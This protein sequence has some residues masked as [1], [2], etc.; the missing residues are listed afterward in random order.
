MTTNKRLK[1]YVGQLGD[2]ELGLQGLLA[3]GYS[4]K[5]AQEIIVENGRKQGTAEIFVGIRNSSD[6]QKLIEQTR[7]EWVVYGLESPVDVYL[8]DY[9]QAN[10]I[11]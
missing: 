11:K 2:A 5:Q 3:K 9:D 4:P 7:A 8:R 6:G 1:K 10:Q